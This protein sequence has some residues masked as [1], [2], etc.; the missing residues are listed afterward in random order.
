MSNSDRYVII[1]AGGAGKR[2][3]N[4]I[5]KQIMTI[6]GVPI[7][8]RTI[9]IFL[10]LPFTTHIIVAINAEI[11]EEWKQYCFDNNFRIKYTLVTG[12]I[13]RFHSVKN[14]L[15]YIPSDAIVAVHDGVRPVVSQQ[16]I[17]SLFEMAIEHP[18]VIP[19][20]EVVDSMR[21]KENDLSWKPIDRDNYM[22]I[23][24][25]QVFQSNVLLDSY[26]QAYSPSF[27]DDASVVEAKGYPLHYCEGERTNIKITTPSDMELVRLI[28]GVD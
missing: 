5:P 21:Q 26:Q 13:T 18:A 6:G 22:L 11:K 27:T 28:L 20:L 9:E 15:K 3:G 10:N 12:G 8:R 16:M 2:M 14:C 1:T 7:L 24:T 25:P 23:Q 19:T 4:Q 17:V